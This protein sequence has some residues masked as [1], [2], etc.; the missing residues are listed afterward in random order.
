MRTGGENEEAPVNL[1]LLDFIEA[2]GGSFHRDLTSALSAIV[3][4]LEARDDRFVYHLAE[5]AQYRRAVEDG[6]YLRSTRDAGLEE[7]G[8][9]HASFR[10]QLGETAARH[11]ADV[12]DD[13]L[14][15]LEIDRSMLR[16]ELRVEEAPG[17]N[18][19]FPHIYGALNLDAVVAV[20]F[21]RAAIMRA[22]G[23][24]ALEG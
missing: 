18:D 23:G 5:R 4:L 20:R 6:E 24:F 7:V 2:S 11:Y 9:I 12:P 15:L 16:S 17:R 22:A 10:R 13:E 3:L 21:G 19:F 8:F 1:Q 14:V